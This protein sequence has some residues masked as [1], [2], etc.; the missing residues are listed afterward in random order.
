MAKRRQRILHEARRLITG[1]GIDAVNLRA[2]ARAAEVTV[3]TIYNLVG[4]KEALV[5]ALF[6][7]ALEEIEQR[8]GSHRDAAPLDMAESVATESTGVFAEDEQYYRAAFIAVEH[9]DQ[10]L[11]HHAAVAALYQWA[12]R[13]I[14]AG[15]EAC[16]KAGLLRGRIPATLLS[17]QVLRSYR[18]SCRAWAFGQVEIDEFRAAALTDVYTSLAADAVETFH[19]SLIKKISALVKTTRRANAKRSGGEGAES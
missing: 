18:T 19:A 7:D 10:T 5:V 17:E 8:I 4:N 11:Q 14:T 9:L 12:E 3:P 6:A 1:G 13:I 16:A 2:L 15:F